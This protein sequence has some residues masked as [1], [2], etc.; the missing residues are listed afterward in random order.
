MHPK[1][2]D[3]MVKPGYD[4][5][6]TSGLFFSNYDLEWKVGDGHY[7]FTG[8]KKATAAFWIMDI[9]FILEK[10]GTE[11]MNCTSP[12]FSPDL[13]NCL[14]FPNTRRHSWK[15]SIST[16]LLVNYV[17]CTQMYVHRK[18]FVVKSYILIIFKT[19]YYHNSLAE[20]ELLVKSC[21]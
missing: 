14:V 10:I 15:D 1:Y 9:R 7:E 21:P 5:T 11:S 20:L 3:I 18:K 4:K 8:S 6:C 19:Q 12:L 13:L 2:C 17:D 16:S